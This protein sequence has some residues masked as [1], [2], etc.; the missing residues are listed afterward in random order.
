MKCG[1]FA[2]VTVTIVMA[3]G[4]LHV[5][6]REI[7]R[8]ELEGARRFAA[9]PSDCPGGLAQLVL[10]RTERATPAWLPPTADRAAI[11]GAGEQP[12][13]LSRPL[14]MPADCGVAHGKDVA[15]LRHCLREQ[16]RAELRVTLAPRL[17]AMSRAVAEIAGLPRRHSGQL[18]VDNRGRPVAWC[19]ALLNDVISLRNL[20]LVDD[21]STVGP[22]PFEI[23]DPGFEIWN[24]GSSPVTQGYVTVRWKGSEPIVL[25][26]A[27]ACTTVSQGG[28]VVCNPIRY[29]GLYVY[30]VAVPQACII[31]F[32][33]FAYWPNW[34]N[35]MTPIKLRYPPHFER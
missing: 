14:K 3:S 15:A 9:S 26:T 13:H 11:E 5:Q 1:P 25:K 30:D 12:P 29:I 28:T 10:R 31:S 32:V 23:V 24:V 8:C 35:S 19:E 7:Y 6:A 22:G 27:A 34:R 33:D 20:E 17:V 18:A 4:A 21:E 2:A 16:R